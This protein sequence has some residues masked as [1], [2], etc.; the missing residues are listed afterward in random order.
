MSWHLIRTLVLIVAAL[1]AA[2]C[3]TYVFQGQTTGPDAFGKDRTFQ[4][5]WTKTE[6]LLGLPTSTPAILVTEC[7]PTTIHFTNEPEGVVFRGIPGQDRLP[8]P[9]TTIANNQVCARVV[10]YS[11]LSEPIP[12]PLLVEFYC[13]P[14]QGSEFAPVPRDYPAP[15][16]EPY[17]FAVQE[18]ARHWRWFR[19][20]VAPPPPP[21]C[22]EKR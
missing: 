14:F 16:K 21:P 2:G 1:S 6:P 9:I 3:T 4:L 19:D 10:N 11:N 20:E 22:R 17:V 5:Y 7:T 13:E 15:R 18:Q 12:G 8:G